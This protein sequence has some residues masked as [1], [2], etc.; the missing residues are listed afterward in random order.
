MPQPHASTIYSTSA[1]ASH[2]H[3][4]PQS[5]S[6]SK[7]QSQ[8]QTQSQSQFQPQS[9]AYNGSY[10]HP[11]RSN[12]ATGRY[13]PAGVNSA[14]SESISYSRSTTPIN[15]SQKGPAASF[16]YNR[17]RSGTLNSAASGYTASSSGNSNSDTGSGSGSGS[18]RVGYGSEIGE[19]RFQSSD[20]RP[21]D[22]TI[23]ATDPPPNESLSQ[24]ARIAEESPASPSFFAG[25]LPRTSSLLPPPR[26]VGP[27][28]T[29]VNIA[30][31]DPTSPP[32]PLT[33][34]RPLHSR[35]GSIGAISG[36][37]E[38]FR[39][40]NR[41]SASTTSSRA[42]H[43][44][45][46]Q[47]QQHLSPP[48]AY[49]QA[50]AQ[51]H[52]RSTTNFSRRMSIDSIGILNQGAIAPESPQ[53]SYYSPRRLTKRRPST[54]SIIAASPRAT[55]SAGNRRPSSPPPVPP[56][57]LPPILS[58]PSL[59]LDTTS[60]AARVASQG[61]SRPGRPEDSP[62]S[63]FSAQVGDEPQDYFWDR[64]DQADAVRTP[65]TTREPATTLLPAA[66]VTR[67]ETMPERKGHTRSRSSN[68]KS[69]SDSGRTKKQPSQK[70]MLSKALAKANTA[71]QLD[72][73]QNYEGAR[74]SYYE[75]CELLAQVLA[76]TT[77]DEDKKK[78][79]AIRRT[80]TSRVEELDDMVPIHVQTGGKALPARP[81]SLAFNAFEVR[82][83]SDD[84]EE[85]SPTTTRKPILVELGSGRYGGSSS[86][87]DVE[88]AQLGSGRFGGSSTSLNAPLTSSFSSR[89]P[90]S[91]SPMRRGF[92]GSLTIPQA[93]E[94]Q[95]MPAPLSPRRAPSPSKPMT[96]EPEQVARQDFFMHSDRLAAG[97]SNGHT[98]NPSHE[99]ISWLDPIDESGGSEP[100]SVHSR[101]SSFGLRRKHI[102][103]ISGGT[104]AEFDA[105]LDAAVE[106]AYD[107][108]FE[109]MDAYDEPY[110]DDDD[111]VANA[112]RRVELAKEHVR[113][114]ER[115][116]ESEREAVIRAAREK[117][118]QRQM[119]VASQTR[120]SQ[121]YNGH[122]YDGNDSDEEE[123]MLEDF[124]RDYAF[125]NFSFGQQAPNQA[126]AAT[127]ERESDSSGL[128][129]RTWHS[130]IGSSP[131]TATTVLSSVAEMP[132]PITNPPPP[133]LPPPPQALPQLPITQSGNSSGVRSRRLSGQNA[134]QLKIE[135]T[136]L[137]QPA[138]GVP[139]AISAMHAKQGSF[140]AQQRQ[141][142]SATSTK[143]GPFSMRN[144]DSPARGASPH[145]IM[146]PPTPPQNPPYTDDSE[147]FHTGSP[148]APPFGGVLRMKQ[149]SSSLKSMK[150]RQ[151]S[152]SN[153]DMASDLSPNTP[154]SQTLTNSSMHR[155]PSVPAMPTP[156]VA[157]FTNKSVG[158]SGGLYLFDSDLIS[159]TPRSPS[160]IRFE[161]PDIPL[162]LEPCPSDVMLRPFWLMRAIYQTLAH[163]RGGYITTRLFVPHDVWKVKGVK[164]RNLEDK[165][166]QCDF[167]TAALMKLARVDSTD[168]DAVLEEMQSLENALEQVQ[169][170][171]TRKLGHEV[172][173]QGA[174]AY[175]D[176]EDSET[177]PSV[178]RSA[179]V[180]GKAAA[181]SWR[182]L[183]SKGSAVNL[184]SAYGNKT[185]SG[186]AERIAEREVMGAGSGTLPSL[187]MVAQPSSRP[188]KRDIASLR[189]DG[190]YAGYMQSLA[191]LF[192]AAQT[193]DQIAR[194]VEDPGLRHADKTQVGLELCTRHAAEFFGFYICRF[195]LA[196]LGMLLDK[197]VKRGSEWVLA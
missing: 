49:A 108:G 54:A 156:L 1:S 93:S 176:R 143:P 46:A 129:Q 53:S 162:P 107:D 138:A 42:S 188:A 18:G 173:T 187:P 128:T 43:V 144:P 130:S 136:K 147:D 73:A 74:I 8:T 103:G 32:D 149:S 153:I 111:V 96:P 5:Q 135:T 113:Q 79:E 158:G 82:P 163:P 164:L 10:N 116:V 122:F 27:G 60:F 67:E 24:P 87:L 165:S 146:S 17:S 197:F 101:T 38:G 109:P 137:G 140:I 97:T 127:R 196:D 126:A 159:P 99:S 88:P 185:T 47:P 141:A 171:L 131:P 105:A 110:D 23:R 179:S 112:M 31:Y 58:L 123:R 145:P 81:E 15:F 89:S 150:I 139:G 22:L 117:E 125:N 191:R 175:R 2:H 174:G 177:I 148:T 20:R 16:H 35:G 157:T 167:L 70:A 183:R 195:V 63:P 48:T 170:N 92:E 56:P 134:K 161:N 25:T 84:E 78:L 154:L 39:N 30:D 98:R 68:A 85:V 55:S 119:S 90:M 51:A 133:S 115:E 102:R 57:N 77:G 190:P 52:P 3:S 80:Y 59:E 29:N 72:N 33:N 65:I 71:V 75:A 41:W 155:Q 61:T 192:D 106:A 6:Q 172:G 45:G 50:Q 86:N 151:M 186:G 193:L 11:P 66:A 178:P 94:G 44:P 142:M 132:N 121:T 40:L 19:F 169:Q 26:I 37:S 180:S 95:M 184:T 64:N 9:A 118:R 100:S 28:Q 62:V 189:F 104:E 69:S 76:R 12:T 14:R 166:S 34:P 91:K 83:A 160:S 114:A 124:T 194:Q 36:I 120:D 182:R 152:V 21:S 181:F 7:S 4:Q 168:A 13:T